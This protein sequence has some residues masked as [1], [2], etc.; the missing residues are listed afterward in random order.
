M[1]GRIVWIAGLVA[2]ALVSTFAQLDREAR[3]APQLAPLVPTMFSGFAVQRLTEIALRQGTG[4]QALGQARQLVLVRPL[5]A[6]H[7]TLLSQ[8]ALIAGD[9]V[10]GLAALQEA[11][12]RGW[13]E[14]VSQRAMA[15]SAMLVENWEAASQRISALLARDS[16]DRALVEELVIQ[17]TET[18]NG[19]A[20]LARRMAA[21]GYWQRNFVPSAA[22]YLAPASYADLIVQAQS[23]NAVLDCPSLARAAQ[24]LQQ[25]GAADQAAL[26]WPG[27]C[28]A[29]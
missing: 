3:A 17:L 26:F 6:E 18:A 10:T 9:E 1:I 15:Q 29:G 20:A 4:E 22:V 16:I 24:T 27:D 12:G 28:P 13:R 2:A 21:D 23:L 25:A 5:P 11:G 19:R 8:A 7:L 14:P